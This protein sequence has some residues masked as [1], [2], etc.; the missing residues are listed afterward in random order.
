[1]L[2]QAAAAALQLLDAHPNRKGKPDHVL[3]ELKS[4]DEQHRASA[5]KSKG[6]QANAPYKMG[7]TVAPQAVLVAGQHRRWILDQMPFSPEMLFG[8]STSAHLYAALS[9]DGLRRVHTG[10]TPDN[11]LVSPSTAWKVLWV[12]QTHLNENTQTMARK[13]RRRY[14]V[15][16]SAMLDDCRPLQTSP[17]ETGVCAYGPGDVSG[18]K[19]FR[20]RVRQNFNMLYLRFKVMEFVRSWEEALGIEYSTF[21]F[22]REDNYFFSKPMVEAMLPLARMT[23]VVHESCFFRGVND[24]IFLGGRGS[25]RVLLGDTL[26]SFEDNLILWLNDSLLSA[27]YHRGSL[28]NGRLHCHY[29]PSTEYF[30]S[31]LSKRAGLRVTQADFSRND[32]R[33]YKGKL[34]TPKEYAGCEA[35]KNRSLPSC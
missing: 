31:F 5:H 3:R 9:F 29:F 34:C 21:M 27:S 10:P 1:M 26:S 30:Y 33:F 7:H 13:L 15:S 35:M 23:V 19:E 32:A 12:S 28:G 14:N 2:E 16:L 24:K 8:N 6:D 17:P 20:A 11:R 22:I 25:M 4:A 18:C